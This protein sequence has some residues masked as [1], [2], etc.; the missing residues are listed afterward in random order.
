MRY[1]QVIVCCLFFLIHLSFNVDAKGSLRTFGMQS[2]QH[3]L[4]S[5]DDFDF[6]DYMR[7]AIQKVETKVKEEMREKEQ[8]EKIFKQY[9]EPRISQK[10]VLYDLFSRFK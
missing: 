2:L 5:L 7:S 9:L 1:F 4:E 10:S 3:E 6:L 8:R